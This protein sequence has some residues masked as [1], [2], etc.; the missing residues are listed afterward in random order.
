MNSIVD[1]SAVS[2]DVPTKFGTE[3]E[4]GY[5]GG[6]L[7]FGGDVYG[8][9]I[10]PKAAGDLGPAIWH[11]DEK[12]IAGADSFFDGLSNTQAMAEAGSEIAQKVL[13]LRINGRDDW[14]IGSRDQVELMYRGLKPTTDEN[15]VYRYGDNPSSLPPGYPYTLHL[16]GQTEVELFRDG[17]AEA[18]ESTWYFTSTQCSAYYAW[19]QYFG[20]GCQYTTYKYDGGRFRAVRMIKIL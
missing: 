17:G 16:P 4:G 20:D 2:K 19:F 6:I 15:Y 3:W 8:Q 1:L 7:T 12:L 14:H 5:F 18:F 11:P 10:A 13:D 9:V